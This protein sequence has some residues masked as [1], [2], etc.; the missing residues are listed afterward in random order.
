MSSA[1][2]AQPDVTLRLDY[3]GVIRDVSVAG[4]LAS[5]GVES[6]VGRPW[7]DTVADVGSEKVRSMVADAR[8]RSV[9]GFRQVTQCFPSGRE[10]LIEYATVRLGGSDGLLAIGRSLQAVAELQARLLAAQREIEREYWK[11][12]EVESRYRLLFDTS[13]EAVLVLRASDL[14][15]TEANPAALRALGLTGNGANSL[16]SFQFLSAVAPG[17]R[18]PFRTL[19]LRVQEQGNAPATFLHLGEQRTPWLVRVSLSTT[20]SGHLY[21]LQLSAVG[22][23]A[24]SPGPK[25][26]FEELVERLPAGLVVTDPRGQV[27]WGNRAFLDLVQVDARE[28]VHG[29]SLGRWLVVAERDTGEFVAELARE[30]LVAGRE[31]TIRGQ[32]GRTTEVRLDGTTCEGPAARLCIL[33]LQPYDAAGADRSRMSLALEAIA[34]RLGA[35]PLAELARDATGE[36]ERHCIIA[37]MARAEGDHAKAAEIL[38]TSRSGLSARIRRLRSARDPQESPNGEN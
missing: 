1:H 8:E 25:V 26:P 9:S 3:D 13:N 15:V 36:F 37:A 28:W 2:W 11:L 10:L 30:G 17:E 33:L 19:L 24:P 21:L 38:G 22:A 34:S 7:T 18:E 31:A 35:R 16:T 23:V 6:L 27:V 29:Q 32:Q 20:E 14:S 4:V 5:E 12:R